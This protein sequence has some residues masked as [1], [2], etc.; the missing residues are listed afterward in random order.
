MQLQIVIGHITTWSGFLSG[1]PE[2]V[3]ETSAVIAADAALLSIIN[4]QELAMMGAAGSLGPCRRA[5]FVKKSKEKD[6][7]FVFDTALQAKTV[8]MF[9]LKGFVTNIPEESLSSVNVIAY[10]RDLWHVEQTLRHEHAG[11]AG[12][13]NLPSGLGIHQD[14]QAHLL[15]GVADGQIP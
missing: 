1:C 5:M 15:H 7:P 3:C 9:G 6:K 12:T 10:Y 2:R 8:K 14:P 4:R 11:P 13:D